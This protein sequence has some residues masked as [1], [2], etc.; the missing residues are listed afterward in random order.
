MASGVGAAPVGAFSDLD[1]F[2]S[3]T[4]NSGNQPS[5]V[6]FAF[7]PALQLTESVDVTR[8]APVTTETPDGRRATAREPSASG[9]RRRRLAYPAPEAAQLTGRDY[10]FQTEKGLM[11]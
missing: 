9:I 7:A 1:L 3:F 2:H 4:F 5:G 10:P 11:L 6:D 8:D